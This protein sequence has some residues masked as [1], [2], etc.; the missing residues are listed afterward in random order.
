MVYTVRIL[1]IQLELDPIRVEPS[2]ISKRFD[3]LANPF[4]MFPVLERIVLASGEYYWD[5]P[6]VFLRTELE[7]RLNFPTVKEL[8]IEGTK[9]FP[10]SLLKLDN[11][12][13]L[14]NLSFSGQ[15]IRES[16]DSVSA[17]PRLQS[18]TVFAFFLQP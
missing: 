1:E 15:F 12:N 4:L 18:L 11:C 8:S 5:W 16:H 3:E 14:K 6:D 17:L 7:N 9:D 2:V 13:N 10:F